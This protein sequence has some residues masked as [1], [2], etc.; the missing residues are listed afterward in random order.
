M[1][2]DIA[3]WLRPTVRE[4]IGD[5]LDA[6]PLTADQILYRTDPKERADVWA[7]LCRT[8]LLKTTDYEPK[9]NRRLGKPRFA[10]T[11]EGRDLARRL[12]EDITT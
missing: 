4:L 5:L 6:R 1:T 2:D 7:A 11:D 8:G 10:L 3:P 9:P 12:T